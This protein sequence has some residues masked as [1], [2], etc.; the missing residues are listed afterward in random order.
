LVQ[1]APNLV[2]SNAPESYVASQWSISLP[3]MHAR[4]SRPLGI[5][6]SRDLSGEV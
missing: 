3:Y 6:P 1:L 2:S 5:R 4:L